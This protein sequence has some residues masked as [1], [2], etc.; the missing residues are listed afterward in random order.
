M[1]NMKNI[2]S[3]GFDVDKSSLSIIFGLTEGSK[4]I[5]NF[6]RFE[7]RTKEKLS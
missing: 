6:K 7:Y 5:C 1:E 2:I 3:G 4:G